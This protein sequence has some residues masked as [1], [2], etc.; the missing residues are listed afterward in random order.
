MAVT[1]TKWSD[2]FKEVYSSERLEKQFFDSSQLTNL[3]SVDAE[4]ASKYQDKDLKALKKI[5]KKHIT[6]KDSKKL[7]QLIATLRELRPLK[8]N[9]SDEKYKL[10]HAVESRRHELKVLAFYEKEKGPRARELRQELPALEKSLRSIAI[11]YGKMDAKYDRH[12]AAYDA[13][14]AA[15][16]EEITE[17]KKKANKRRKN[18]KGVVTIPIG[19]TFSNIFEDLYN[20]AD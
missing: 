20:E 9:L 8:T 4:F 2:V 1:A 16:D 10:K 14:V 18:S 11:K 5:A 17:Y 13:L 19:R 15:A 3:L 6:K 7:D 12:R